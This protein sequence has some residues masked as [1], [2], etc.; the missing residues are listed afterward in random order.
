MM[1][2]TSINKHSSIPQFSYMRVIAC[3]AIVA[4]HTIHA[5]TVYYADVITTSQVL[6]AQT[7]E[8]MLMWA[9]PL[10]LMVTGALQ[11]DPDRSID[12][13]K[14]WKYIRRVLIALLVFTFIF[15][16]IDYI[17]GEESS[18]IGG[19]F[20]NLVTGGS[21]PHM[22]YLYMLLGLYLML[23]FYRLVTK[24]CTDRQI[25]YLI[26]LLAVF[27]SLVPIWDAFHSDLEAFELRIP[28]MSVYPIYL[29]L[30]YMLHKEK[31][32]TEYGIGL[33]VICSAI[34]ISLSLFGDGTLADLFSQYDSIT[35]IAQSAG[36]FIMMQNLTRPVGKLMAS[37]DDCSF[38]IYIIHMIGVK[39]VMKW[40]GFDPYSGL[41]VLNFAIMV[42]AFFI[43]AYIITWLLRKIP[44]LNLL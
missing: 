7:V 14:L 31:K 17:Y 21:W 15:Q 30:G 23:P 24:H 29:F 37:V 6:T 22:W 1:Q 40:M 8:H 5:S 41:A 19:W 18:L 2:T 12:A 11:L 32:S 44:K 4:L 34:I 20:H 36:A 25:W 35:V 27:T 16:L 26:L 43:G 42:I 28:T 39:V 13:K 38:G 9:V 10:F 3:L 33:F